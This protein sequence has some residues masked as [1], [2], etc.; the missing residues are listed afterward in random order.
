L[1]ELLARRL[2]EGFV[3]FG[4]AIPDF[5]LGIVLMLIVTGLLGV[6]PPSGYTP[7]LKDPLGNLRYMARP[8]ACSFTNRSAALPAPMRLWSLRITKR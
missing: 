7:F 3:I 5:W 2:T 6:L 1:S 4:I 8:I